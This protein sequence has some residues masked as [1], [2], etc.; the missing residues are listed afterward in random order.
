VPELSAHQIPVEQTREL[1]QSILRPHESLAQ[2]AVGEPA[3]VFAAGVLDDD[4]T[5]LAVGFIAP[6]GPPGSWRVRA[7][8]TVEA[9]RGQ[10]YGAVVLERLLRHAREHGA[11]RVWCNAR[12]PALSFYERAGFHAISEEFEIV[13]IGPH[14]VMESSLS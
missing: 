7:M 10:G 1:R 4:G 3:E 12:T 5:A 14:L 6:D 2:L 13:A 8:A 11:T 9:A